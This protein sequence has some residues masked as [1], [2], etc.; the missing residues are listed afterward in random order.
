[1]LKLFKFLKPYWWQVIILVTATTLQVWTTLRLPALMAHII[2][3]GIVPGNTDY[4][5]QVGAQMIGLAVFSAV[6]S[7]AAGYLSARIGSYFVRDLR[8]DIYTKVM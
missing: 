4:I 3:D 1:M 7:L 6:C 8:R 2:N 5:W